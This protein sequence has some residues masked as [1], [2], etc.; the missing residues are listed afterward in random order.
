TDS[1][2]EKVVHV[3][4]WIGNNEFIHASDKVRISSIKEDAENYDEFNRN[5]YLRTKRILMEK[6]GGLISLLDT[7]LFK[8]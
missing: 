5:R 3:G 8:D 2:S 1:T 7:P 6:D 4:I